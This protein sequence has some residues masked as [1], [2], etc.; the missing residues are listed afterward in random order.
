M[1]PAAGKGKTAEIIQGIKNQALILH[2]K[3]DLSGVLFHPTA[4]EINSN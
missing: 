3:G 4:G 1:A 2:C